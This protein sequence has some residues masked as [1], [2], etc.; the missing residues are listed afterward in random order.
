M[1]SLLQL[2]L[3][4]WHALLA[5]AAFATA[6]SKVR[7][8]IVDIFRFLARPFR[9][10]AR[11]EALE[12]GVKDAVA[13]S[14]ADD[15][16]V[17]SVIEQVKSE[18]LEEI[19]R[20]RAELIERIEAVDARAAAALEK[21]EEV[22]SGIHAENRKKF[23]RLFQSHDKLHSQIAEIRGFLKGRLEKED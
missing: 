20:G 13:A 16:G 19:K 8:L 7:G 21:H 12:A 17:L 14:D 11:I 3:E 4:A 15:R 10:E 2:E 6:F 1:E 18:I 5:L 9:N 23:E 22:C